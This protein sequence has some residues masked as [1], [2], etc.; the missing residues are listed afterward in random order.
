MH[1]C[2]IV[3]NECPTQREFCAMVR[4]LGFEAVCAS[5]VGEAKDRLSHKLLAVIVIDEWW[6]SGEDPMHFVRSVP[7]RGRPPII[8][9][10]KVRLG[11]L[12]NG[13]DYA[14]HRDDPSHLRDVLAEIELKA[15]EQAALVEEVL[16]QAAE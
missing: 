16:P 7:L 9:V 4:M 10:Q 8:V 11:A 5:S 1:T 12:N 15:Q 14:V 6:Q 3:T 13:A 2:L